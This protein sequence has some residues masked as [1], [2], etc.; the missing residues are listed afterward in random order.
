M[1]FILIVLL[2]APIVAQVEALEDGR[3]TDPER[4][5]AVLAASETDS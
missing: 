5:G 1:R 2:A 4:W 3:I